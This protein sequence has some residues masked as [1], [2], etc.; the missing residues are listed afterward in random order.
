MAD[1]LLDIP[2]VH[3]TMPKRDALAVAFEDRDVRYTPPLPLNPD[4]Q[5]VTH[6]AD[7]TQSLLFGKVQWNQI[8]AVALDAVTSRIE[9]DGQRELHAAYMKFDQLADPGNRR[10]EHPF[11]YELRRPNY[12]LGSIDGRV[13]LGVSTAQIH[14]DAGFDGKHFD[15]HH[16]VVALQIRIPLGP[17]DDTPDR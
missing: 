8:G 4:A 10:A 3:F 14:F 13:D 12:S 2:P 7:L 16:P 11:N 17:S 6:L 1:K 5:V 9:H 15:T